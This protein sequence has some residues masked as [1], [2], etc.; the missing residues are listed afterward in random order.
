MLSELDFVL[1][2]F[3][4]KIHL[5]WVNHVG[6]LYFMLSF[7]LLFD[8]FML[9]FNIV[10]NFTRYSTLIWQALPSNVAGKRHACH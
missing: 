9:F 10:V 8:I 7:S 3:L 2:A 4:K 5:I 6:Y 1:T